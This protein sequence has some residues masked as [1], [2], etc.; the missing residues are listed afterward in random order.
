M[1]A[2]RRIP[3]AR[4]TFAISRR[5][6]DR[7][8]LLRPDAKLTALF[9]WLLAVLAP[10]FGVELNAVCV[11]STHYH[12]VLTVANQRISPFFEHLNARL[13]KGVNVLRGAR[14]GIVWEP[15]GLSI[16]ELKTA[17]AI[18]EAMA[19]AIANPVAA[20]LVWRPEDWPG[21]NV[22]AHEL[23]MRVLSA[24]RPGFF[25]D[26]AEWSE[27]TSLRVVIPGCLI[28]LYGE[29]GA[30]ER[31]ATEVERLLALA[32]ADIRA[33]YAKVLG[34]VA[35]RNA[36][37]FRR[38]KSWETFGEPSPHFKSGRGR[39]VERIEAALELV[40]FRRD[41]RDAWLRYRAGEHDVVFPYGT[42]LMWVR[43]HVRVAPPPS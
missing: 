43:H 33:R 20:G 25:F 40:A 1:T 27:H 8:F 24:P 21:L 6:H 14:R 28:L 18:V 15:G 35:A 41:Y 5:V 30:R 22:Q 42:Y 4:T 7:R 11:M 36:S 37:P 12:L 19:Y 32:R 10:H 9:S 16:V 39:V 13:A 3:M 2:P 31:I 26:P 34:P 23:G 17:D 38:A 29:D